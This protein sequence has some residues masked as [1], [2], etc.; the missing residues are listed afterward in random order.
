[1][2]GHVATVHEG[3]K[4]FKCAICDVKF[5]HKSHLN[6]HVITV[7]EGKKKFKCNIFNANFGEKNKSHIRTLKSAV[8]EPGKPN[9]MEVVFS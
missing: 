3:K 6:Q 1:M 8:Q 2:N 5:G 9:E 4:Q 7:H